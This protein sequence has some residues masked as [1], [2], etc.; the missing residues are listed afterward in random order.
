MGKN[1]WF[2]S[3]IASKKCSESFRQWS[4]HCKTWNKKS[5]TKAAERATSADGCRCVSVGVSV[6]QYSVQ[7][8][9]YNLIGV[10]TVE[11]STTRGSTALVYCLINSS[12]YT[13]TVL[14][15]G[16]GV[17]PTGR[18]VTRDVASS[19]QILFIKHC[20]QSFPYQY[21]QPGARPPPSLLLAPSPPLPPWAP[22]PPR[23]SNLKSIIPL[24]N[25]KFN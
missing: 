23:L 22:N 11:E 10:T 17:H 6:Q 19:P 12:L 21:K 20:F 2:I 7:C 1:C 14:Y 4:V 3:E 8:K 5:F 13:G 15:T 16:G 25:S 18:T 9:G 24:H